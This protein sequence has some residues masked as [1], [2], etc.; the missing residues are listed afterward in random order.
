[1]PKPTPSV[2]RAQ[3]PRRA[4]RL[5]SRWTTTSWARRGSRPQAQDGRTHIHVAEASDGNTA[6]VPA[7]E[8]HAHFRLSRTR[9]CPICLCPSSGIAS[10]LMRKSVTLSAAS[11]CWVVQ[12]AKQPQQQRRAPD[13]QRFP[14]VMLGTDGMHGD[15]I[16]SAP[17]LLFHRRARRRHVSATTNLAPYTT[18]HQGH[19]APGGGQNNLVIP[20]TRFPTPLT[21][22]TSFPGH[23]C[24]AFDARNGVRHQPRQAH[25]GSRRAR[26]HG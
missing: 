23:F 5:P 16:R 18:A 13:I 12:N 10:I 22:R 21:R 19:N 24:Y 1:M 7:A 20:S 14:R 8:R 6:P 2:L 17:V 4:A 9:A 11:P 15:M 25:R 26:Q 3:G